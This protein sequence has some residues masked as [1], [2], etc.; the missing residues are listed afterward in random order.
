MLPSDKLIYQNIAK[1]DDIP[2]KFRDIKK[3]HPTT[4]CLYS[5]GLLMLNSIKQRPTS[6]AGR[7]SASQQ[8]PRILWKPKFQYRIHKRPPPVAILS[9]INPVHAPIPLPK[10]PF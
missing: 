4:L 2:N 7:F 3:I 9:Q 5:S 1:I 10:D 8:I 6:E